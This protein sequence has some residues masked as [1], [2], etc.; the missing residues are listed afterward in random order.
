[1]NIFNSSTLYY[2]L[3]VVKENVLR[4]MSIQ[5]NAQQKRIAIIAAAV[6]AFLSACLFLHYFC[7]KSKN[8]TTEDI[9]KTSKL[10][11]LKKCKGIEDRSSPQVIDNDDV[12][13]N[14]DLSENPS[15]TDE[16][17]EILNV[18]YLSGMEDDEYYLY[19]MDENEDFEEDAVKTASQNPIQQLVFTINGKLVSL[20][21]LKCLRRLEIELEQLGKVYGT[22]IDNGDC[23]WDAFAQGLSYI[24]GKKVTIKELREK[25]SEE[26]QRFDKCPDEENWVKKMMVHDPMDTYE[27]YRDQ[28][29]LTCGEILEK[30]M[31]APVWGQEKRDG[32]ILCH[33]FKVNLKVFSVGCID[34]HPSKMEDH[35]NFYTS[36]DDYPKDQPYSRTVEISLYPDHFLP[37]RN[38][39]ETKEE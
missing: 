21:T 28:V 23:F 29:M 14:S 31:G 36:E 10:N 26:I 4:P 38:K 20:R 35:D 39:V 19:M 24:L 13:E 30:G 18:E 15:L 11:D 7:F 22:A 12:V 1:M 33:L 9:E 3:S 32:V 34:E 16:D 37:V 6:F 27:G 8:L 2:A 5:L 17:E 25:V